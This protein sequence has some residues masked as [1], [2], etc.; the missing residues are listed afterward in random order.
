MLE[1]FY[2]QKIAILATADMVNKYSK[3]GVCQ[4]E[5]KKGHDFNDF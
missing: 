4:K 5:R 2:C 1:M 3:N